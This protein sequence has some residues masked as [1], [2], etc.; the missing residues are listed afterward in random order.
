GPQIARDGK[1]LVDW[2]AVQE[3]SDGRLGMIGASYQGFAQYAVASQRPAALKAIFPEIAGF[4]DYTSMFYPGGIFVAALSDSASDS[5]R[6]DDLNDYLPDASRPH[7]PSVPVIDE[8]GDG[9]LRDEIPL[10][11]NGNGTFLDD[12]PPTYADGHPRTDLYYAASKA[13]AANRNL[14]A[15]L[16]AAAPYRDSP[17]AGTSYRYVDLDPGNKPEAIA[18]S[19]IAVYNRGG[20]FDYHARDTVMWFATLQGKTPTHVMMAP[21][22][23][24]GL[25]AAAGEAIYRSGPYLA[26]LGDTSST[27]A[28]MNREKLAFFDHYVKGIA[29][30]FE[31]RPP[32]LLYVMG[33]GWRYEREWP[34]SRAVPLRLA[35]SAGGRLQ[36][37]KGKPGTDTYPVDLTASTMTA[38]ANRWNFALST[39]KV[40][41]TFD[42]QKTT[43]L[44][45]TGDVLAANTE[46]TG[47]PLVE[48]SLASTV[49]DGD[50]FAYL[51]DVA[52][53]GTSLLVTEGQLRANYWRVQPVGAAAIAKPALPWHGYAKMD[54]V[55]QP[56]AGGKPL[57]L[58]FDMMPT[59]WVFRQGHRIRLSFAGAD[60]PAFPLHPGLSAS[61]DPVGADTRHPVWTIRR[62]Q[63]SLTLPVVPEH[64]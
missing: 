48:L 5:I 44:T 55:P 3:W 24:G 43:R 18:A 16:V 29:N 8:D 46:V 57:T 10:D 51:E 2:I 40:P 33:K 20:W 23:H 22:G 61:N 9:D 38:G 1:D 42:G 56:F 59:A 32:V 28:A 54:Y 7:L 35:L 41:L 26:L 15:D 52:P 64:K 60:W 53:D 34:L 63:S 49:A 12:G 17:I 13:H 37:G 4:D 47:H 58:R 39:S 14:P 31:R 27:N 36:P 45:Y 6:H 30:G 19:G 62:A 11:R 50:V 25:P 21:V